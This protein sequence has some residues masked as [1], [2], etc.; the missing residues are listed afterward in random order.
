MDKGILNM[1]GF[2]MEG[3][4]LYFIN[5]LINAIFHMDIITGK[6]ECMKVLEKY[7]LFDAFLY[8]D[9]YI[10]GDKIWFVP[11]AADD[12]LIYHLK[13]DT[14]EYINIPK[15]E[16]HGRK[17]VKFCGIYDYGQWFIL[18]PAEYPAILKI[19]KKTYEMII[20]KWEK[21][22]HEK[23]PD[24][25]K[26]NQYVG[27]SSWDYEVFND[28]L[29]LFASSISI[30]YHMESDV[31][32]FCEVC[33]E[34]KLYSGV[35]RYGDKFAVADRVDSELEIWDEAENKILRT[36]GLGYKGCNAEDDGG[37][38][39]VYKI[40]SG[41]VVAQGKDNFLS[42]FNNVGEVQKIGLGIEKKGID[43]YFVNQIKQKNSDMIIPLEG[44]NAVLI[45]NTKD[46]SIKKIDM[47]PFELERLKEKV[48]NEDYVVENS[49]FYKLN[50]L[51][52]GLKKADRI[53]NKTMWAD[54]IGSKI[55]QSL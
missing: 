3:N 33:H 6:V 4:S 49:L 54:N 24:F 34:K 8:R 53:E 19:N 12:I 22:L 1:Y 39:W 44:Q 37:P 27:I 21:E 17:S 16:G 40:S 38:L 46:W 50:N 45:I 5:Q 31:L 28:T 29:Y 2:D 7:Q 25:T 52:D 42:F 10:D 15:L 32:Y 41:I 13:S 18:V 20:T 47:K 23:Y 35:A 48:V 26:N 55:Y 9:L 30:Q 36:Y 51:F 14:C 43:G 11:Y